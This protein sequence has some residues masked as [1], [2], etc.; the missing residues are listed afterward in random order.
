MTTLDKDGL[1]SDDP[2]MM[3][4][5]TRRRIN[6]LKMTPEDVDIRDIARALTM[7][8]RYA[9]HVGTFYSV[10]EHSV[11]VSD[12]LAGTGLELAG[13]LHDAAE[14]YLGDLI[15]PLK[16][17]PM[18]EAYLEAEA[19]VEECIAK[20][21]GL[22]HPMPPEVMEA[23]RKVLTEYE[24][25]LRRWEEH[26]R[27]PSPRILS[28]ENTFLRLFDRLSVP[29]VLGL[30]GYAQSGKDTFARFLVEDH[31]FVRVA[32]ADTLREML[33]ALNPLVE[34]AGTASD[35]VWSVKQLVDTIGWERAKA[36]G[37]AGSDFTVRAYLQRLGTEAGREIL[38]Q[39]IWVDTAMAKLTPGRRY[40]FTDVR[41]PNEFDAI[42]AA[43]GKVIRLQRDGRTAV[44]AH[45]SETALDEHVFDEVLGMRDDPEGH[46]AA[47]RQLAAN[48]VD[49]IVTSRVGD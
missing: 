47:L 19:H 3:T 39:N 5:Y 46:E 49:R 30:S 48:L 9:G 37:P 34:W 13:L 44:N 22:P 25:P 35:P 40:V 21:F 7:Q 32:F 28:I 4:T 14:A 11:R 41:F 16:H 17:G 33:Y 2:G 36:E 31:G 15:R 43:G 38:G 45:P 10:A 1:W 6:P 20:A 18:G 26:G 23:D 24:L 12:E 8:C 27:D 42:K 29:M